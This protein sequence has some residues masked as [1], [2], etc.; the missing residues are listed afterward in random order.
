MKRLSALLPI[1]VAVLAACRSD[2][3]PSSTPPAQTPPAEKKVSQPGVLKIDQEMLRDLRTTTAQ[4]ETRRGGD[5]ATLLG[6]IR[7]N[8][9]AY[10]EVGSPVVA[11]V[12]SLRVA[13]GD[14]VKRGQPLADLQSTD[15]GKAR[16][17]YL[18]ARARLDLAEQTLRRKKDL[19]S[20]QIVPLREVEEAE[21]AATSARA[22][23]RASAAGLSALGAS[24]EDATT[25][26][27]G[28]LLRSPIAGTVI[29]RKALQGQ[30]T[31]PTTALF[32]IAD[33]Q[34]VW[35]TVH[36]FERDVVRIAPRAEARVTFPALPGNTFSGRVSYIGKQVSTESRTV[37]IRIEIVNPSG[38]L[39]P[40]MSATAAIPVGESTRPV[41]AVPA[42]ALQRLDNE[43]VVFIPKDAATY[44]I[45]KVGRGRDLGGEVEVLSGLKAGETIVV[46]GSFLLKSEADKARGE[47]AH[48][49]HQG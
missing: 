12:V 22:D 45:R 29:E 7:V 3:P 20:E 21:A 25:A 41:L 9:N 48:E 18:N 35:L 28:F 34:K 5:S 17:E 39:R 30:M 40:G 31:D 43:W 13:A 49:G 16:A 23:V 26:G 4:V 10:A 15:L 27:P 24:T 42:A 2:A 1:V 47:G 36:A 44:E 38:Q 11:R 46:D 14:S 32:K 8:E 6:E 19:V 37:P 33:L